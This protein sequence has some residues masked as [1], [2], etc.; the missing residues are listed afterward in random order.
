VIVVA[1]SSIVIEG[2]QQGH[3]AEIKQQ[4]RDNETA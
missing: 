4:I 3:P 1:I 2:S